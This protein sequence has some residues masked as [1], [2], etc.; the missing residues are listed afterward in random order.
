[1]YIVNIII[2]VMMGKENSYILSGIVNLRIVLFA[3]ILAWIV[4]E[5]RYK[6]VNSKNK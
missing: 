1:M 4:N 3:P 6:S 2:D 5:L